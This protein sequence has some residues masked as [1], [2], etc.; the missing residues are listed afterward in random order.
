MARLGETSSKLYGHK[1]T[2]KVPAWSGFNAS[3]ESLSL[4]QRSIVGDLPVIAASPTELST[5]HTVLKRSIAVAN[6]LN[7][8][9]VLITLDQAIK[10]YARAQDVIAKHPEE[11][12]RVTLRLGSFHVACTFLAV[13]GQ[14]FKDAG[15]QDLM[16]ESSV[17]G[18]S[19]VNEVLNGKHYSRAVHY[20]KLVFESLIAF[21]GQC[22]RSG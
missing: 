14:R 21:S 15:L 8:D 13:I 20:R 2:Q 7:Q 11:F 1:G 5:V 9:N 12:G 18:T 4:P 22:L 10:F 6:E 16:V 17:V 19:S 3:I